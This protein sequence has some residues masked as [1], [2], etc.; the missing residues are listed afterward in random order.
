MWVGPFEC[1]SFPANGKAF[2]KAFETFNKENF[3]CLSHNALMRNIA[4]IMM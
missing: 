1:Y 3:S 2:A 4:K